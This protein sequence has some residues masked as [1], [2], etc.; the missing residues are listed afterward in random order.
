MNCRRATRVDENATNRRAIPSSSRPHH[1]SSH[2]VNIV[3]TYNREAR[4]YEITCQRCFQRI[5]PQEM[6]FRCLKHQPSHTFTPERFA[7]DD[8]MPQY[9]LGICTIDDASVCSQRLC[10][11]CELELPNI[12]GH[13][14]EYRIGIVGERGT[15]KTVFTLAL[16]DA[17]F[18]RSQSS[19]PGLV[20]MFNDDGSRER[21]LEQYR[22]LVERGELPQA[23]AAFSEKLDP[24]P[25]SI[26]MYDRF[27]NHSR[28]GQ[29]MLTIYDGAGEIVRSLENA[30]YVRYLASSNTLLLTI[31]AQRL[32]S[33]SPAGSV[34]SPAEVLNAVV[35]S[36]KGEL[37]VSSSERIKKRLLIVL[38]KFDGPVSAKYPEAKPVELAN[39]IKGGKGLREFLEDK[40]RELHRRRG[41]II[42]ILRD[43]KEDEF[44]AMA[45]QQFNSVQF[46]TTS[47]MAFTDGK[48]R[49]LH[50]GVIDPL[51]A[52]K[53]RIDDA[54][55][56][57]R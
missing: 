35:N 22:P 50:L 53:K 33:P 55:A 57:K 52:W 18:A 15:G 13:Y 26:R 28:R 48:A 36:V 1:Q 27:S 25:I 2:P 19:V 8:G 29:Y 39:H 21:F 16:I 45:S 3:A 49:L 24:D 17:L 46:F 43:A 10:P 40:E 41:S 54:Q 37:N 42:R 6:L 7:D 9:H 5:V 31:D 20:P 38:T 47:A 34:R 12:T 30:R 4:V 51:L 23:T 14:P 11:G 32:L 44:L 56:R